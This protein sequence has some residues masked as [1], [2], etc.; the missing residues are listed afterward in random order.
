MAKRFVFSL[1]PLLDSRR[2]SEEFK[3]QAFASAK[4]ASDDGIREIERLNEAVRKTGVALH[5]GTISTVRTTASI[6]PNAGFYD[7]RLRAL[8][9][10]IARQRDWVQRARDDVSK[11]RAELLS[12]HRERLVLEKV[13]SRRYDE[14][15]AREAKRDEMEIDEANAQLAAR[16]ASPRTPK[17]CLAAHETGL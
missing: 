4:R 5:A 9:C 11:T 6:G 3:L 7:A 12:A 17:G 10:A 14:F 8:A 2:R 13:R 15:R 16:R 1:E